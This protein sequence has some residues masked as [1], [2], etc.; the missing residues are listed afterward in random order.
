M[1]SPFPGM[2]PYLEGSLWITVHYQLIAEIARQLAPRISPRYLALT[3]EHL[4]L[5][6]PHVS[7]EIRDCANRQLV[8]V[9][10]VLSSSDMKGEDRRRRRRI[11]LSSAHLIEIDLLREGKRMPVLEPL[12]AA[13]YFVFLS[14]AEDRPKT[15]TWPITLDQPL[16]TVPVPLSPGGAD[17]SLDLQ[18]AFTNIYDLLNYRLAV[19]YSQGPEVPLEPRD[20]QLVKKILASCKG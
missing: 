14:R 2:D 8:T 12:P 9:I 10:E 1:P 18:T 5:D 3:G 20:E 13:P 16:P 15:A 11:L 6:I 19:D 17:V 4:F 7:V